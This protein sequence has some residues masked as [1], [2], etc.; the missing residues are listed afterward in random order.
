MRL[1]LE[2]TESALID[3]PSLA[4]Q[5]RRLGCDRGQGF[6]FARPLAPKLI[7]TLLAQPTA[8]PAHTEP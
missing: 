8:L 1:Q 2:L 3:D 7:T 6:F 5:A 4:T